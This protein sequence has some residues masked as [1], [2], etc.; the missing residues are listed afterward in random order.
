MD[1]QDFF[2]CMELHKRLKEKV[3]GGIFI[4]INNGIMSINITGCRGIRFTYNINN[5]SGWIDFNQ[6][7]DEIIWEYK[8][9]INNVFLY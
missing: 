1:K 2:K 8:K 7:I 6:L 5:I 4:C 9:F 3:K